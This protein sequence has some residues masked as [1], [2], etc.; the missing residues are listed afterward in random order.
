[1]A[2]E[3]RRFSITTATAITT[4]L[5]GTHGEM[6]DVDSS[7]RV[8]RFGCQEVEVSPLRWQCTYLLNLPYFTLLVKYSTEKRSVE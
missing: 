2:R 8:S 3:K 7:V 1:M 5:R 4:L 6:S